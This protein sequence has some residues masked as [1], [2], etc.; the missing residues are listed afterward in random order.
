MHK[1][2][3]SLVL[4]L[5]AG[6]SVAQDRDPVLVEAYELLEESN[7]EDAIRLLQGVQNKSQ[8]QPYY[9]QLLAQCL[10]WNQNIDEAISAY[11]ALVNRYPDYLPIRLD[12]GRMLF[13]LGK[14]EE[15]FNE[16]EIFGRENPDD[17]YFLQTTG[18]I[19]Y[20]KGRYQNALNRFKRILEQYPAHS[21]SLAMVQKIKKVINPYF[22][23]RYGYLNDTQPIQAHATQFAYGQYL[24]P[25]VQPEIAWTNHLFNPTAEQD[26]ASEISLTNSLSLLNQKTQIKMKLGIVLRDSATW[27]WGFK[28]KQKISN[29]LTLFINADQTPYWN[30][31][32]S[33]DHH[34]NARNLNTSLE[35]KSSKGS[36]ANLFYG[37][38][39]FSESTL[40]KTSYFWFTTPIWKNNSVV[41]NTGYAFNWSDSDNNHFTPDQSL[42]ELLDN[43]IFENI[44]GHYSPLFTPRNQQIHS[45]LTNTK[46]QTGKQWWLNLSADFG[47]W[48]LADIPYLYLDFDDNNELQVMKGFS[49][50][51][52]FTYRLG[53]SLHWNTDAHSYEIS[54]SRT[55]KYFYTFNEIGV[56]MK[57]IRMK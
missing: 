24:S 6:F 21:E 20:W 14:S 53:G 55:K 29:S 48:A 13:E 23:L 33:L 10:Y 32:S 27:S 28:I 17:V 43:N 52:F 50:Q 57:F 11:Q 3:I 56:K 45:L 38:Q 9:G 36:M 2:L 46:I 39:N 51:R 8:D 1:I 41:I 30:T 16:L 15:A 18:Y 5:L 42:T 37:H 26:L 22:N 12:Y 19:L 35:W 7:F 54:F 25:W 40:V 49:R 31:L 34:I 44:A 4:L 47:L